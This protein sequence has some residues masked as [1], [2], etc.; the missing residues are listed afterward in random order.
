MRDTQMSDNTQQ[1]PKLKVSTMKNKTI[2]LLAATALLVI[3]NG[4][5][6]KAQN[7]NSDLSMWLK[8][9]ETSGAIAYDSSGNGNNCEF[10]GDAP[11]WASG[12]VGGAVGLD[13]NTQGDISNSPS[14]DIAGT[15]LTV[16][17]WINCEGKS[18]TM[19]FEKPYNAS[20]V[21][22]N[23]DTSPYFSLGIEQD[24]GRVDLTVGT[25]VGVYPAQQYSERFLTPDNQQWFHFAVTYDGTFARF[26][27]NGAPL[28][29]QPF[30]AVVQARGLRELVGD[31]DDYTEGYTGLMDDLHV[32]SR[33]LSPQDIQALYSGTIVTAPAV[34]FEAPVDGAAVAP[35]GNLTLAANPTP[36][37]GRTITQ[38]Q[39][40]AGSNSLG[41]V[42]SSPWTYTWN[43]VPA[44][45]YALTIVATDDALNTA[46]SAVVNVNAQV[47]TNVLWLSFGEGS[48]DVA[49]DSSGNG[50]NGTFSST[51]VWTAGVSNG[52]TAVTFDGSSTV[53]AIPDSPSL[54]LGGNQLTIAGWINPANSQGSTIVDMPFNSLDAA[55]NVFGSPYYQYGL[56]LN[57]DS[58]IQFYFADQG[59][60]LETQQSAA[61]LAPS[62]TWTHIAMT[63]DGTAVKFYSNAV[64]VSFAN[65]S[66]TLNPQANRMLIGGADG[67]QNLFAGEMQDLRIYDYALRQIDLRSL[68]S[69][70]T[71]PEITITAPVDYVTFGNPANFTLMVTAQAIAGRAITNVQYF[72]G[73][74][75]LGSATTSPF[76]LPATLTNSGTNIITA[77]AIDSAGVS[78]TSPPIHVVVAQYA[79]PLPNIP[80]QVAGDLVANL[81]EADLAIGTGTT[82]AKAPVSGAWIMQAAAFKPA[83]TGGGG[84]T[85][86]AFVQQANATPST[87]K[88]SVSITFGNP[89]TASDANILAIGWNDTTSIISSVTDTAG[90]TYQVAVPTVS[91]DGLSQAIYYAPNINSGNNTVTV[92]FN[93]PAAYVD[94]RGAEY[95]GLNT[96]NMFDSGASA[97]GSSSSANS[98]SLTLSSGDELLFGA[99]ITTGGFSGAG[100]GFA[101]VVITPDGD[102][103]EDA[104]TPSPGTTWIN[105]T[106]YSDTVGNFQSFNG[107]DLAISTAYPWNTYPVSAL[108]VAGTRPNAV[109]SELSVASQMTNNGTCSAEAWVYCPAYATS[110]NSA[111][112]SYGIQG[113]PSGPKEDREMCADASAS[114]KAWSLDFGGNDSTWSTEP[115]L[116]VWHYLAWTYDGTNC[117]AYVDGVLG[118]SHNAK[119][120]GTVGSVVVVG[121]GIGGNATDGSALTDQ[122]A[123]YIAAARLSTGVLTQ[124]QVSNNY[125]AGLFADVGVEMFAPVLGPTNN[126]VTPGTVVTLSVNDITNT[127]YPMTYQ[128]YTD[129]GSGGTNW[130]PVSGATGLT[131]SPGTATIGTFEYEVV[132]TNTTFQI[133]AVSP[134]A[135]LNVVLE[136]GASYSGGVLTLTWSSGVLLQAP[137]VTGPWTTNTAPSPLMIKPATNGPSMFY[138]LEQ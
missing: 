1:I 50:N 35:G 68:I 122:Y 29:K 138:K 66:G 129:N 94:L 23:K 20:D 22:N 46:T 77:V 30:T 51:P 37:A 10:I 105:R 126:N 47:P 2:R 67:M 19:I 12:E 83:L 130:S 99:G 41:T 3:W 131:Y 134:P 88:A 64:L 116:N 103:V 91:G 71:Q 78:G 98:G 74:T 61:G 136:L 86:P 27:V 93:K 7:T 96:A 21:A 133:G 128:W 36:S 80:L 104:V 114:G 25:E 15:N 115:S 38:V 125:A 82:N 26:Y 59:E 85:T 120:I 127:N 54:D 11:F 16:T 113:G 117:D 65:H 70:N 4:T 33:T 76:S 42:S 79:P 49:N 95:S 87:S 109:I 112:V 110:G 28:S 56:E 107:A 32:Y 69:T 53:L 101:L 31:S 106:G 55:Q 102:I 135:V 8:F 75:L 72:S 57:S 119:T 6:A 92:S 63:W 90:N 123:G 13:G 100:S 62:G 84:A 111:I 43:N 9:D 108:A 132:A 121:A 24:T 60:G 17:G 5:V 73:S 44:G 34:D 124:D 39:F 97:V 18:T 45:F 137:V 118:D 58:S 81:R 40:F 14:I 48:G 89:Q 52:T